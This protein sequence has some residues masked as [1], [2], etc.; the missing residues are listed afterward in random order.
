MHRPARWLTRAVVGSAMACA[1]PAAVVT[2]P[3]LEPRQTEQAPPDSRLV[4]IGDAGGPAPNPVLD[5][6][7]ASLRARPAAM[8]VFLGDN[9]YPSGMP[10]HGQPARLEAEGRMRAQLAAV[11]ASQATGIVVPGNHDWG[12]SAEGGVQVLARQAAFIAREGD[13]RVRLHPTV[14]CP[15][16]DVVDV[17]TTVRLVVLDTEWW[18]RMA[19]AGASPSH[20]AGP[21][22]ASHAAVLD[23]LGRAIA[24]GAG[25]RVIVVA[26]HPLVSVGAHGGRFGWRQHL[27]PLVELHPSLWIPL[28]IVGSLYPL[29]ARIRTSVQE[30]RSPAYRRMRVA[31]DSVAATHGALAWVAGHE[32]NL[33]L[34]RT[35]RGLLHVVSGSGSRTRAAFVAPTRSTLYAAQ[36]N[37]FMQLDTWAGGRAQ[38]SVLTVDKLGRA[39]ARL[40]LEIP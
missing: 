30:L 17:G 31:M 7:Q 12:S 3:P 24:S 35:P 20:A 26:H 34:S 5:A 36:A 2:Q 37:G 39:S 8:A 15:G 23:S 21:C 33:Q 22:L 32:H 4:F 25:R 38:L 18:L 29:G 27:F 6:V 19:S 13:G 14:G 16:P 11:L 10:A 9:I 40:V 28:P 1:S